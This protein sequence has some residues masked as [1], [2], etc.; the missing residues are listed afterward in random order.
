MKYD[1]VSIMNNAWKFCRNGMEFSDALKLAWA[2]A[3][4]VRREVENAGICTEVH[5]WYGWKKRGYMVAH[6]Q[7]SILKIA[8]VDP[9]KKTGIANL[10]YFSFAQVE[11]A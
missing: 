2:N 7:K 1:L 5:T 3:K 10:S 9:T 8:V 4:V 11:A 6:G